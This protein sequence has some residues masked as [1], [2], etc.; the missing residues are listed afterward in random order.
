MSDDAGSA[1]GV[2]GQ[3]DPDQLGVTS[4]HEHTFIDMRNW[5]LMPETAEERRLAEEPVSL[6]NL[7][8]LRRNPTNNRDNYL[9]GSTDVA[10]DELAEFYRAGGE[11]I[12]DVTPKGI[13]QDP[14]RVREISRATGIQFVHGTAYYV[15]NSHPDRVAAA[16]AADLEEEFVSDVREGI[17]GT[18]VRAGIIGEIGL[19]TDSEGEMYPQEEKVLRAAARA[20]VRTGAPLTIHPPGWTEAA[21]RD[22]TYPTSRWALEVLDIVE[23]TG[24]DPGRVV[25]DHMDRSLYEDLDYQKELASRGPYLEYD[26]WGAEFYRDEYN[27]GFPSDRWRIEAVSELVD[28]GYLSQLLFA[29]DI[30]QKLQLRKYG[31]FGYAHLLR[32]VV[33]MLREHGFS[34]DQLD[35]ILIDN[36]KRMLTFDPPE[37]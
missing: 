36:P 35:T 8:Y 33:P 15:R 22:R 28:A 23:E 25:M 34:Q 11:T 13:G 7:W 5:F 24:L 12:V 18:D 20:A 4:A 30:C 9:L 19:S 2:N 3:I 27:D 37:E 10:I 16:S 17:D 21:Q 31:G 32:N 26:I 14:R 1:V 29:Q 6:E